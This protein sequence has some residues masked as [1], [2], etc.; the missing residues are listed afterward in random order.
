MK[1]LR[2]A[3]AMQAVHRFFRAVAH[4]HRQDG[5]AARDGVIYFFLFHLAGRMQDV[6][7]D[8]IAVARMVDAKR[9]R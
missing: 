6:I 4:E 8:L 9:R 5:E 3:A 7:H 2:L 1:R